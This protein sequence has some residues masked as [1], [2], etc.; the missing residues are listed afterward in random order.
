MITDI[1][2]LSGFVI[3]PLRPGSRSASSRAR[4][5]LARHGCRHRLHVERPA[6]AGRARNRMRAAASISPQ[7]RTRRYLLTLAVAFTAALPWLTIWPIAVYLRSPAAV[8]RVALGQQLR[9][10][11]RPEHSGPV[12]QARLLPGHPALVRVSRSGSWRSGQLWV[13]RRETSQQRRAAFAADPVSGRLLRAVHL[14]RCAR[15]VR[16]AH[17]AEALP[18]LAVPGLPLLRRGAANALWWF[19]LMVFC[20][21][22]LVG[23]FYWIALDLNFPA[24]L[25]VT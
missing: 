2:L 9:P 24:R 19:A 6:G 23:W 3:C 14:A 15:T 25:H 18:L 13:R 12:R 21:F 1:S 5:H 16:V 22:A 10:L 8:L 4:G 11:S 17:I 7:W 20:F